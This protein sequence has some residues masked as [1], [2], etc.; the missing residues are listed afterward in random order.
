MKLQGKYK[1]DLTEQLACS[2]L[3]CMAL[4]QAALTAE[5]TLEAALEQW[6]KK[7]YF[8]DNDQIF[9]QSRSL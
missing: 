5:A 4:Q 1:A 9:I 8:Q 2:V 6:I 7:Q 3:F